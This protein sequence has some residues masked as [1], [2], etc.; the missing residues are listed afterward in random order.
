V[1][2]TETKKNFLEFLKSTNVAVISTVS[3]DNQPMSA[4]I[5]YI[6][7]DNNFNFYFMSKDSRKVQN[8]EKNNKVALLIGDGAAPVTVQIHGEAEQI[9]GDAEFD[10]K[11]DQLIQALLHNKFSP[12]IFEIEGEEFKIYK[13]KPT[14]IRW[15]DLRSKTD[16][17][18]FKEILP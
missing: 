16:N 4:I 15:L 1:V 18:G 12:P 11:R 14:W 8:I 10:E 5:Y 13:I 17:K 2:D 9:R 3:P 6:V 7:E